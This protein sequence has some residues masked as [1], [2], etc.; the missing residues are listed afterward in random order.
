M[1]ITER[2][3][4]KLS[5]PFETSPP[6]LP[7]PPPPQQLISHESRRLSTNTQVRPP[8]QD[9]MMQLDDSK[10]KVYIYSIDDELSSDSESDDGRLVLLPDI[11]KH[12]RERRIPRH[13]LERDDEEVEGMQVVLYSDPKSLSVPEEQ[14]SVRK[15]IIESRRRLRAQRKQEAQETAGDEAPKRTPQRRDDQEPPRDGN[16]DDDDYGDG[17]DV[18]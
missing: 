12:L 2:G 15:A 1:T 6:P 18:D 14:D 17:M 7:P 4:S 13:I 5:T 8:A 10:H 16:N 11:E 3:G 9:D